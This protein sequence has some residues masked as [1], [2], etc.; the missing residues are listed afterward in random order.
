LIDIFKFWKS[1]EFYLVAVLSCKNDCVSNIN[2]CSSFS[3]TWFQLHYIIQNCCNTIINIM[4]LHS[5]NERLY[6]LKMMILHQVSVFKVQRNVFLHFMNLQSLE[7]CEH[8]MLIVFSLVSSLWQFIK[9]IF[10]WHI[11]LFICN[12]SRRIS[13]CFLIIIQFT[14]WNNYKLSTMSCQKK[15]TTTVIW[16][17]YTCH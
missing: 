3:K 10:S 7:L 6:W 11:D 15:A 14:N 4:I 17:Y 13:E 8:E 5:F 2:N 1:F 12:V 9:M 16:F